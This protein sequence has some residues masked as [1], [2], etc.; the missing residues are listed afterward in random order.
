MI[1]V[2]LKPE[3]VFTNEELKKIKKENPNLNFKMKIEKGKQFIY[4]DID[5]KVQPKLH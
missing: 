5:E 2:K 1:T 4:M 3:K